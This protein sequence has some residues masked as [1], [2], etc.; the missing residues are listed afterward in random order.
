MT[1]TGMTSTAA[2]S[3]GN[4]NRLAILLLGSSTPP[5]FDG[6]SRLSYAGT[7]RRSWP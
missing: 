2:I 4:S 6:G 7:F 3:T 5:R 1:M